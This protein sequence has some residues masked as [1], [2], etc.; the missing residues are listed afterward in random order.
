MSKV[1]ILISAFACAP[2]VGSEPYVGWNWAIMLSRTYDVHVITRGGNRSSI[3]NDQLSSGIRF[4]YCDIPLLPQV[5]GTEK[6]IK[7]YYVIWQFF[8]LFLAIKINKKF[9]FRIV[10][11]LTYNT[12]DVPGLM[13]LLPRTSFVWGPIGG[14]QVPPSSLRVVFGRPA[15][16]L[17]RIRNA[18]K[19]LARFRPII[20]AASNRAKIVLFANQDTADRLSGIVRKSSVLLETAIESKYI[21]P[22]RS[23]PNEG[24]MVWIGRIEHRKAL[25]LAIDAMRLV[26]ERQRDLNITLRVIGDGP[27]L[28]ESI[29]LVRAYGLSDAVMFLGKIPRIDVLAMVGNASALLFTSVQDTSGNVVL[30]AMAAGTPVIALRHQGVKEMI[31]IGGGVLIPPTDYVETVDEIAKAIVR[32]HSDSVFWNRTSMQ[33]RE[34]VVARHTWEAKYSMVTSIYNEILN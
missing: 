4:H 14:G 20:R 8:A 1:P 7:L 27:Q 28:N 34:E 22:P 30:E 17:Q 23:T 26:R 5:K 13:W 19:S 6:W 3:E 10:Q 11:Q 15:W 29:A 33:A 12:I 2:G 25:I 32:L 21:S 9:G 31:T 16:R 24:N 18:Q